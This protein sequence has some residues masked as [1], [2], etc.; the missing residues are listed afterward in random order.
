MH[1]ILLYFYGFFVFIFYWNKEYEMQLDLNIPK[2]F[3]NV[4][5]VNIYW[6]IIKLC[7]R[8]FETNVN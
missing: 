3:E 4:K 5:S 7:T 1:Y 6:M 2:C 8:I